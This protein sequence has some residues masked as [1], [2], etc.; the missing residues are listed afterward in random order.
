VRIDFTPAA[1]QRVEAELPGGR[2]KL[3]LLYDT[4]GCGC[5]MS[6]VPTLLSIAEPDDGDERAEGGPIEVWFQKR[7]EVFFE[8]ALKIDA[9]E[10]SLD[11]VL[12]SDNQIYTT[13]LRL[14]RSL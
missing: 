7:Y 9:R 2:Q 5:V 3:K 6:G 8:E 1:V 12:K 10:G 13:N 11:F 4:E 14:L